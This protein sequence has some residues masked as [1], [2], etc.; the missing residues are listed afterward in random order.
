MGTVH[1]TGLINYCY[2]EECPQNMG[3]TNLTYELNNNNTNGTVIQYTELNHSLYLPP[4]GYLAQQHFNGTTIYIGPGHCHH[5]CISPTPCCLEH[6][7]LSGRY[8]HRCSLSSKGQVLSEPIP[9][10]CRINHIYL[11]TIYVYSFLTLVWGVYTSTS[12]N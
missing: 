12:V 8:L 9:W 5:S 2:N 3:H 10:Q 4:G 7:V 1:A 6:L 11:Q